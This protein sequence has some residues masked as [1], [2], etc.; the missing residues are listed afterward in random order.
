MLLMSFLDELC[1]ADVIVVAVDVE[2]RGRLTSP[3]L[4][5]ALF[6]AFN[7]YMN[8]DLHLRAVVR[9]KKLAYQK[10]RLCQRFCVNSKPPKNA[11]F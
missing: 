8:G 9:R 7:T 4:A 10:V 3:P 1:A 6:D 2:G 5:S 11:N